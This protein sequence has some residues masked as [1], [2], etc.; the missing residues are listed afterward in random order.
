[1]QTNRMYVIDCT[2]DPRVG[3]ELFVC[4]A[5]NVNEVKTNV[6]YFTVVH[7]LH[8]AASVN[9]WTTNLPVLLHFTTYTCLGGV[10]RPGQSRRQFGEGVRGAYPP[11]LPYLW[12]QQGVKTGGA[13][14]GE[15]CRCAADNF[16]NKSNS[17][18]K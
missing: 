9:K 3:I 11:P 15:P 2:N 7:A 5:L 13:L 10:R 16:T 14:G 17:A 18:P 6:Q 1:M 8:D 4:F 12:K